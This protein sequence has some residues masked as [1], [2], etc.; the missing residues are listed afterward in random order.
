MELGFANPY[1]THTAL[2]A[3]QNM[4]GQVRPGATPAPDRGAS[5]G[6][7]NADADTAN[8][9][10]G[11]SQDKATAWRVHRGANQSVNAAY[12]GSGNITMSQPTQPARV[13]EM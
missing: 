12:V 2:S 10:Y 8:V 7:Q 11:S 9:F 6:N 1:G 4:G 3:V 13:Q 5:I